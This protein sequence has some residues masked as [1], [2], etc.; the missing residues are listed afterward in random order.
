MGTTSLIS[1]V[2][3]NWNGEATLRECLDSL[4]KQSYRDFE[5]LVV[6]N[7]SEDR[8]VE[9]IRNEYSGVR[10]FCLEK[11]E[12]FTGACN[13][14]ISEARGDFIALLNNDM[15]AADD[16]LEQLHLA[17]GSSPRHGMFASRI[18]WKEELLG[19]RLFSAGDI[20]LRGGKSLGRGH[21]EV[22]APEYE[23]EEDVFGPC[24]GA[25][26]YRRSFF[27]DV[28]MFDEDFF[29]YLEDTDL[30]FR[31]QLKGHRCLYVP[32]AVTYH[33]GMQSLRD[34]S[35]VRVGYCFRNYFFFMLKDYP[36]ELWIENLPSVAKT[37]WGETA[38]AFSHF[39][40]KGG[41][42]FALRKIVDL[43]LAVI[44]KKT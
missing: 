37:V 43:C 1:I 23:K 19:A 2:I 11:N 31:G 22:S 35:E 29:A 21:D 28:G 8:S 13:V 5:V 38:Y 33:Y 41:F 18:C 44:T 42:L 14:G 26:L 10:L 20:L 34:R 32:T 30:S 7:A 27:D 6:D 24:A 40:C 39:R 12:G 17:A 3:P 16:W 36:F 9:I 25:A 15:V 4:G